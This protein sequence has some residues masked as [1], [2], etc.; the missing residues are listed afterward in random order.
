MKEVKPRVFLVGETRIIPE[1][2]QSYL[3]HIG[4]PH[5]DSNAQSDA[6]KL[7]E[8]YG[9]LC[10]KSFAIGLN[11][12]IRKVRESNKEYIDH[13]IE[14]GHGSVME[15]AVINFAFADVSRVF[16]HE[17][18]RHRAG[19]AISQ[20]S[21]RFVRLT[22]LGFW[23]PTIIRESPEAMEIMGRAFEHLEGLQYKL[24]ELFHIDEMRDF[25]VKK[26][27]TSA[28][29]RIAPIGLATAIGWSGN[30]RAIRHVLEMRTDPAAEEEIRIVFGQ[31]GRL[32]QERYPNLFRDYTVTD[33][34]GHP[35]FC[36]AHRKV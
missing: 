35:H 28:F 15:H 6:E 17:L 21:L 3:E 9:K 30:I 26:V 32:M 24:A 22:D 2:M 36:T 12:N 7:T 18:V 8:F 10:Y 5:W 16:T 11:H 34:G 25:G 14:V 27:L 33:V 19:V 20:E 31:V 4:A 29:R 23:A 1:G 13:V